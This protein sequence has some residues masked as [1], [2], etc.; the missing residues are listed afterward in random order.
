MS[1]LEECTAPMNFSMDLSPVMEMILYVLLTCSLIYSYLIRRR[2]IWLK[3]KNFVLST[4]IKRKNRKLETWQKGWDLEKQRFLE[5]LSDAFLLINIQGQ[6]LAANRQAKILFENPG[7]DGL[8]LRDCIHNEDLA[9]QMEKALETEGNYIA[10]FFLASPSS[11]SS[12][13]GEGMTRWFIDA[14][15]M[16]GVD[17]GRRILLRDI[18]AN[19]RMEQVRKDFVANASH[20]LRT[21]LTIIV[22]YLESMLDE[23]IRQLPVEMTSKFLNVMHK[24]SLRLQR[25]VEDMLMISKLESMEHEALKEDVFDLWDCVSDVYLRLEPIFEQ[26]Q[27]SME[28][29]FTPEH[30]SMYGDKYYWT[31]IFFNLMENALKQN[32]KTGLIIEVGACFIKGVGLRLWVS[33]NGIGIQSNHLPYIFNRFYRVDS[34]QAGEIKGTGLGLSIVKRAVNA[35]D[36]VINVTSRPNTETKFSIILP[37]DRFRA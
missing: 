5:A 16:I 24:H 20:E 27:A 37:Q 1:L 13:S 31:Q 33:D 9:G 30:I 8:L 26:K 18:T 3:N 4:K 22:G 11:Q 21:P 35:H 7:L 36:G 17:G 15:P 12:D 14:A 28:I 2:N 25:I 19:Y 29:N 32:D 34:H 6:V 10:E 23:D